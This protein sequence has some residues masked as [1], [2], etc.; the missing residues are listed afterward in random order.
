M[1]GLVV[2][3]NIN[4]SVSFLT[5]IEKHIEILNDVSHL[6]EVN[7]NF[8]MILTTSPCDYLPINILLNSQKLTNEPAMGIK[9]HINRFWGSQ[10]SDIFSFDEHI[11]R[12][13]NRIL[14]SLSFFHA[15]LIERRKFGA[16]GFAETYNFNDSDLD[17]SFT[18][19]KN[20][21]SYYDFAPW[22][23]IRYL[24]GRIVYGGRIT[25]FW[26]FRVLQYTLDRFLTEE[27]T[28][29]GSSITGIDGFVLPECE[30]LEQLISTT[31]KMEIDDLNHELFGINELASEGYIEHMNTMLLAE[32]ARSNVKE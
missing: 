17:Q 32:V 18:I 2:L 22:E 19:V 27:K 3:Q 8:R 23:S 20:L 1:G 15:I 5:E 24:V 6:A 11:G 21:I 30:D 28:K 9:S 16:V 13:Q 25:D 14:V 26:D 4:L 29:E 31:T 7:I 12:L 10:N